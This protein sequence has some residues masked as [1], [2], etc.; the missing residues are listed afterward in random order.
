M[1]PGCRGSHRRSVFR[2]P[3]AQP[4]RSTAAV[5]TS[6]NRNPSTPE[7][8]TACHMARGTTTSGC[9]VS[10]ARLAADSNPT[11]VN[12][13]SRKPSIQGPTEVAVPKLQYPS[14]GNVATREQVADAELV[15]D[16]PDDQQQHDQRDHA[17]QFGGHREVVDPLGPLRRQAHQQRLHDHDDRGDQRRPS[18]RCPR[19]RTAT[20][21]PSRR[22]CSRPRRRRSPRR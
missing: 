12:A 10:S 4:G 8:R 22:P 20:A 1:S 16:H 11:I 3:P 15:C 9:L 7:A 21:G 6:R 5:T 13:P 19:S 17:D 14:A 2:T 18:R